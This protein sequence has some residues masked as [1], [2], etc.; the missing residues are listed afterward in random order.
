MTLT[1]A[2]PRRHPVLADALLTASAARTALLVVLGTGL[3][4]VAAQIAVPV[5]G[6]P[7]PVT[8]QSFA[9]LLTAAALGPARALASQ[10][11]LLALGI[12]GLP[13]FAQGAGGAHVVFGATG[14]YLVGFLLA[15]AIV[16][17]GARLGADRSPWRAL[18]MYAL[19]TAAVYLAGA[20]WLAI[21][22]GMSAGAAIAAG[23]VPFLVGDALKAVLAAGLLPAA[24]RLV[25]RIDGTADNR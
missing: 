7:V 23:V 17:Q 10:A 14:G 3:T 16:G 9:V 6:S 20:S 18:P 21:S 1:Y 25:G 22:T 19:A 11:L 13:V 15:A 8:G 5:P 4:A 2:P 24:W 12:A